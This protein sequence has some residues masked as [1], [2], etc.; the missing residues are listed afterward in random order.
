MS[1]DSLDKWAEQLYELAD[2]HCHITLGEPLCEQ[3]PAT[4]EEK[5]KA[6]AKYLDDT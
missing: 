1:V 6:V 3:E 5:L 4:T 2:A